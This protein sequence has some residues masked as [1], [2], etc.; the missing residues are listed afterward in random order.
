MFLEAYCNVHA[1]VR[2]SALRRCMSYLGRGSDVLIANESKGTL[3]N[4]FFADRIVLQPVFEYSIQNQF[5]WELW[6]MTLNLHASKFSISRSC[7]RDIHPWSRP[8]S[9]FP[10]WSRMLKYQVVVHKS[11]PTF[12]CLNFYFPWWVHRSPG[13][14]VPS[15]VWILKEMTN[16]SIY[17][18]LLLSL[19]TKV[20]G[21][22]PQSAH[23]FGQT[24][25]NEQ[26]GLTWHQDTI[27]D[28][29]I[30]VRHRVAPIL[31]CAI[32]CCL[33]LI[34]NIGQEL[35]GCTYSGPPLFV[36][37]PHVMPLRNRRDRLMLI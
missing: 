9:V 20:W 13:S 8:T 4:V 21:N 28:W 22:T 36:S 3:Q 6:D 30:F 25:E 31:N 19:M 15:F 14:Y 1:K 10:C 35:Q 2:I 7:W 23:K 32:A 29:R 16:W 11:R 24:E 5:R 26:N 17:S 37:P 18:D 27:F 33:G 34:Y 12:F